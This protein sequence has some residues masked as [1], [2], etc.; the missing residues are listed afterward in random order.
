MVRKLVINV[1]HNKGFTIIEVLVAVAIFSISIVIALVSMS[2]AYKHE[3]ENLTKLKATQL[4]FA[5]G[6]YLQGLNYNSI[7]NNS[8]DSILQSIKFRN[9][10]INYSF[11]ISQQEIYPNRVKIITIT[12]LWNIYGKQK[13]YKIKVIKRK[14]V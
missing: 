6:E 5:C 4:A 7:N 8:C 9:S 3:T 2:A 10:S 14:N 11:N 13:Q 12:I 1:R